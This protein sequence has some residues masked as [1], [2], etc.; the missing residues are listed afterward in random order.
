MDDLGYGI[1][2]GVFSGADLAPVVAALD[3]RLD[4][5]SRAGARHVLALPEIRALADDPRL[6]S[7]AARNPRAKTTGS[8]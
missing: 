1:V 4:T 6:I 7:M 2:E 3:G 8:R 5:R